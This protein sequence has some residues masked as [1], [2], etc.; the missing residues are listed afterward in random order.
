[1]N[2]EKKKVEMIEHEPDTSKVD[3]IPVSKSKL[4]EIIERQD[5]LEKENELLRKS[6]SSAKYNAEKEKMQKDKIPTVRFKLLDGV[7]IIALKS[8]EQKLIRSPMT[9]LIVNENIRYMFKLADGTEQ[10]I[11]YVDFYTTIEHAIAHVIAKRTER[12][13]MYDGKI[14]DNEEVYT[15][16]FIDLNLNAKYGK[17]EVPV[18]YINL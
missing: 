7:P 4:D 5:K 9:G 13:E 10:E 18:P 16:E 1:M 2:E 8:L 3:E 14:H 12:V 6:V 17:I 11:L 15:C